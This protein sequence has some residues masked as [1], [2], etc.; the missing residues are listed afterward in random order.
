MSDMRFIIVGIVLIFVGFLVL[1]VFGHNYQDATIESNEF[2]TCYEY[3]DDSPPVQ[4]NCSSKVFEQTAF[5]GLVIGFITVG[6][7][8]L[9]KGGRGDW[10]SKVKPEDMVGPGNNQ[11]DKS[12]N[13]K[14]D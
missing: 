1:G 5:F 13:S 10:D 12:D 6:V 2:E 3:S 8:S 7:I 9:I 14:K 11:N 4:I